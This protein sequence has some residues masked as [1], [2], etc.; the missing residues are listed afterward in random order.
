MPRRQTRSASS[1]GCCSVLRSCSL[2]LQRQRELIQLAPRLAGDDDEPRRRVF[3]SQPRFEQL[4]Q[5]ALDIDGR[6][7]GAATGDDE[8]DLAPRWIVLVAR[9]ELGER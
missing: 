4:A 3:G 9:G 5:L 2:P 8:R 1:P 6:Q 7:R